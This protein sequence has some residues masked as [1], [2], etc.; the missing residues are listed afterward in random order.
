MAFSFS[1]ILK[2]KSKVQPTEEIQK[3]KFDGGT[4]YAEN[5][6]DDV[7]LDFEELGGFPF[8]KTIIIGLFSTKIKRIGCTLTFIFENDTL[9]LNSDN[10]DVESNQIKNTPLYF[11]EIDF[12]LNDDEAEKIRTQKVVEIQYNFKNKILSFNPL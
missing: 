7:Y 2:S 1:N 8:I 4:K 3:I 6:T 5:K 10:T 9:T 12:E 11:T